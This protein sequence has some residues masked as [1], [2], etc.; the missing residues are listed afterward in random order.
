MRSENSLKKNMK[1]NK[2]LILGNGYIGNYIHNHLKKEGF[3]SRLI[4]SKD[5]NYHNR[6]ELWQYLCFG[7]CPNIVINCSGFTGTPNI[8]EAEIKKEEC[9][10]LNVVSP[11]QVSEL[12]NRLGIKNI[13]ISSGC[14]YDGYEKVFNEDDEPNFG[15]FSEESSF[16]SKS[17]HAFEIHTR[18][19][20]VKILRIRMPIS[21]VND[22]RSYLRKIKNYD[23]LIDFH[24]SKTYIPDLCLFVESMISDSHLYWDKQDIYNVINPDFLRTT[25]ICYYMGKAGIDNPKWRFV[26][27]KNL[28]IKAGRS[29]CIL[30]SYK[31]QR[32]HNMKTETQ[33]IKEVLNA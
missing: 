12:C 3:N 4:G 1:N 32:F 15:L 33:A 27:L 17:K 29:N 28:N 26:Q 8:D 2:V 5:V 11:L 30:D 10:N 25:E 22:E 16:Y 14:I 7:F 19:L 6:K 23:N 31:I 21:S 13:Q 20:P 9:W 18:H 24:N